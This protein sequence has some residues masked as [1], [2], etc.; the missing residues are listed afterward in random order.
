LTWTKNQATIQR[1]KDLGETE[2]L[3]IL[4]LI[5]W[6]TADEHLVGE[7]GVSYLIKT[8]KSAILFDVGFNSKQ[9]DPS[10]LLHNMKYLGVSVDDFHTIVITHNHMDHVGGKRWSDQKTFSFG[11]EQIDLG[12]K[13]VLTPISMTYPGLSPILTE[14]PTKISA[15]VTTTGVIANQL[16]F[17]GLTPDQA[18]AVKVIGKGVVLIV[19]CG[20]QTLSKLLE[21]I[22]VMFDEP[23]YGL[24][25]G[26]HYP[27]TDSRMTIYG[28][29]IQKYF[30]T[31]KT[32]WDPI[33]MKDVGENIKLL[34]KKN[35]SIVALS[36]HDSCDGSIEEF[37]KAFGTR[38]R[39][40]NVGERIF[41]GS[42]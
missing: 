4:P 42:H 3:E 41:I 8:D 38:Y 16:F 28:V 34:K 10:P 14:N 22:E 15:G 23:L 33:T 31:G 25:G 7:A 13:K 36:A 20:H 9:S 11:N 40:L 32:P 29:N 17:S 30:V 27:V 5:D 39:D 19:G 18:I 21:R 24:I 1:I 35:P 6:Q 37:R 12:V 2:T 26:L